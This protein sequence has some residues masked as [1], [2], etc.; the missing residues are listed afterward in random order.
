MNLVF[1]EPA[2]EDVVAILA[3]TERE[4][5]EQARLRYQN[6]L[7]V[8]ARE[9]RADP[10]R[11]GVVHRPELFDGARTFHLRHCRESAAKEG[12]KVKR[13]RH[14]YLFRVAGQTVEIVRVLHD[15]MDLARHVPDDG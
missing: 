3:L 9:L 13:P 2:T 6:L 5:G 12:E 4:F 1:S 8:S 14:L 7:R 15:R 11:F 10:A